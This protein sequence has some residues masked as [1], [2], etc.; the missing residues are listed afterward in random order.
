M[1][2]KFR[3][4]TFGIIVFV[5][6]VVA[7]YLYAVTNVLSQKNEQLLDYLELETMK[8]NL[9]DSNYKNMKVIS[10]KEGGVLDTA[11][12]PLLMYQASGFVNEELANTTLFY[13]ELDGYV[14]L[15]FMNESFKRQVKVKI[16]YPSNDRHRLMDMY[17]EFEEGKLILTSTS[18]V[19]STSNPGEMGPDSKVALEAY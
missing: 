16:P 8:I 2:V 10:I 19:I 12:I 4:I 15:T 1:F 17:H 11:D 3:S 18:N 6:S 5:L 7:I 13:R 14:E 9:S